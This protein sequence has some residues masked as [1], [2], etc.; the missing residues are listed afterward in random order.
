MR[1]CHQRTRADVD[2]IRLRRDA[3]VY[4]GDGNSTADDGLNSAGQALPG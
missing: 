2:V 3:A 1:L 4:R